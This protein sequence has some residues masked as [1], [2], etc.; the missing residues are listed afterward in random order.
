MTSAGQSSPTCPSSARPVR[1]PP[2]RRCRRPVREA[3]SEIS[4]RI[5]H[6]PSVIGEAMVSPSSRSAR[7]DR[8]H[9]QSAVGEADFGSSRTLQGPFAKVGTERRGGGDPLQPAVAE[10][11]AGS[12]TTL[13]PAK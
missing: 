6:R 5:A 8:D 9:L 2:Q 13:L 12:P 1:A 4:R 7:A 11:D 10:A 3:A